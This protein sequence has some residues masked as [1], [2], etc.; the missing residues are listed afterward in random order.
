MR[1]RPRQYSNASGQ[2]PVPSC[3]ARGR[4]R[5]SGAAG[6]W[7]GWGRAFSRRLRHVPSPEPS[8][9][10]ARL[11]SA[12]CS[13]A[14]SRRRRT[15]TRRSSQ[16][17]G[18]DWKLREAQG[19]ARERGKMRE[20]RDAL[21]RSRSKGPRLGR[22]CR[23]SR[24]FAG[25]PTRKWRLGRRPSAYAPA[26]YFYSCDE[27]LGSL[28][29]KCCQPVPSILIFRAPGGCTHRFTPD[30]LRGCKRPHDASVRQRSGEQ[31]IYCEE[32]LH[33]IHE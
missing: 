4:R 27:R 33:V 28:P 2:K 29:I 32:P 31:T 11:R 20:R 13:R 24:C 3:R 1:Q 16:T 30:K 10:C 21:C 6:G 23:S 9:A 26:R 12:C 14:G 19:R 25:Q 7:W 18:S 15:R 5:L 8:A 17:P 22:S